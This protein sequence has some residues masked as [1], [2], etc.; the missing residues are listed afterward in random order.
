MALMG[1]ESDIER[2]AGVDSLF[3]LGS[4]LII[5][6]RQSSIKSMVLF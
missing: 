4:G 3:F 6:T 1:R 2:I 5:R